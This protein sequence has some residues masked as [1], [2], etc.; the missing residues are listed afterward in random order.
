MVGIDDSWFWATDE[1]TWS[2]FTEDS[3]VVLTRESN[4]GACGCFLI[5]GEQRYVIDLRQLTQLNESSGKLRAIH[6]GWPNAPPKIIEPA[7]SLSYSELRS[8]LSSRGLSVSGKKS[9]LAERLEAAWAVEAAEVAASINAASTTESS[10]AR[11]IEA[12]PKINHKEVVESNMLEAADVASGGVEPVDKVKSTE[13]DAD[14]TVSYLHAQELPEEPVAAPSNSASPSTHEVTAHVEEEEAG[15]IICENESKAAEDREAEED[16][17]SEIAKKDDRTKYGMLVCIMKNVEAIFHITKPV[18]VCGRGDQS[19][20]KLLDPSVSRSHA[21][22]TVSEDGQSARIVD[23]GSINGCSIKHNGTTEMVP[24]ISES[25]DG[26]DMP[27]LSSIQMGIAN[28]IWA[29]RGSCLKDVRKRQR[30][31]SPMSVV[32]TTIRAH[33]RIMRRTPLAM[34]PNPQQQQ[35]HSPVQE[36]DVFLSHRQLDAQDFCALLYEKLVARG[37][38]VFLDRRDAGVLHDL[39]AIVSHSKCF[40][41]VLSDGIFTSKWCLLELHAAVT[42]RVPCVPLRLDGAMWEGRVFPDIAAS[43]IPRTVEHADGRHIE[44]RPLLEHL[45]RSKAIEHSREYFEA[46]FGKLISHI[47]EHIP[48]IGSSSS[49]NNQSASSQP[50]KKKTKSN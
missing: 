34:P 45:F 36:Y 31:L 2:E 5:I 44:V 4:R 25:P 6:R 18:T 3:N 37:M 42:A 1:G 41:F 9:L 11:V 29:P 16:K 30:T 26:V 21:R 28:L 20:L 22:I 32:A 43:Y 48:A 7:S 47:Q 14:V 13:V 17:A 19:D 46:F 15:D 12:P 50:P 40:I 38:K 23:L 24:K 33:H 8:E 10:S 27:P 49:S 35:P 39:P